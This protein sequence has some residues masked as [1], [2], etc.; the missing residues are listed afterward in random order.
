MERAAI[1]APIQGSAA[2]IIKRAMITL[3]DNKELQNLNTRMLLQVHD[4]LIFET[5]KENADKSLNIIRNVMESAH[6][7]LLNLSVPLIAD[8]NS[9]KNWDEAH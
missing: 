4:E 3:D 2:D 5:K 8:T 6:K 1:N 9:G 7:P